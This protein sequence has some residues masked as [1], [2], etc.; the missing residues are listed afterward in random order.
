MHTYKEKAKTIAEEL[1]LPW[2]DGEGKWMGQWKGM[3][4]RK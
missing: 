4:M 3:W 1:N 2:H